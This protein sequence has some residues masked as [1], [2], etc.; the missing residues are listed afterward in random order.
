MKK[1]FLKKEECEMNPVTKACPQT[2]EELGSP[3]VRGRCS[4]GEAGLGTGGEGRLSARRRTGSG[5]QRPLC[6]PRKRPGGPALQEL[7]GRQRA[8]PAL[9]GLK[10]PDSPPTRARG[11]GSHSSARPGGKKKTKASADFVSAA[12]CWV[13]LFC[14]PSNSTVLNCYSAF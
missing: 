12:W 7:K 6:Q 5:A 4:G 10:G 3:W 1:I 9:Q 8:G 11:P 14:F 13:F 2:L